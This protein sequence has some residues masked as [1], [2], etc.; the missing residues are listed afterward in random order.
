MLMAFE[1]QAIKFI[2]QK[3]ST[4]KAHTLPLRCSATKDRAGQM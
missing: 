2:T 3:S 1:L 4:A